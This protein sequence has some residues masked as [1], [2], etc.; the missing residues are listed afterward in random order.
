MNQVVSIQIGIFI[1]CQHRKSIILSSFE[2]NA[3]YDSLDSALESIDP[4]E[5]TSSVP[6]SE[7][8][9][10][11]K[12]LSRQNILQATPASKGLNKM[13]D[14]FKELERI[15]DMSGLDKSMMI[16]DER[17]ALLAGGLIVKTLPNAEFTVKTQDFSDFMKLSW[18][19]LEGKKVPS[20]QVSNLSHFTTLQ[21]SIFLARPI[22]SFPC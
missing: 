18:S 2:D 22:H 5:V 12:L 9:K 8:E 11:S 7:E 21:A 19:T 13:D 14:I 1:V 20:S 4:S 16:A 17:C 6:Q 3:D 10:I 15:S